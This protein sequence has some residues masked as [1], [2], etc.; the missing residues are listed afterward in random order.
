MSS[1][2]GHNSQDKRYEVIRS[3]MESVNEEIF[4]KK[5]K[6]TVL[7]YVVSNVAS[8]FFKLLASKFEMLQ[9]M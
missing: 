1:N 2:M 4:F 8:S 9:M 3:Q 7:G 5:K 6:S